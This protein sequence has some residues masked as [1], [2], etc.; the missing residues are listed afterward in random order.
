M[1]SRIVT[2]I[3]SMG[4]NCYA[5]ALADRSTD[6]MGR[7]QQPQ[8]TIQSVLPQETGGGGPL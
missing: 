2:L 6:M 1:P 3:P 8:Q 5:G 7:C 4:R